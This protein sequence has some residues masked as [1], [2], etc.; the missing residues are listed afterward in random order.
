[1]KLSISNIGWSAENDDQVYKLMGEIG[2][3]GLEIAPTR[4]FPENPYD[5]LNIA[6]D[7]ARKIQ[8]E[9]GFEISS[10]QSIWYGRSE[11]IFGSESERAT[12]V[13]YTRKA[14]D[15]AEGVGCKN[16]VFG[17]P[18]NRSMPTGKKLEDSIPFFKEI[19]EYAAEHNCV[20]AMEANPPIYNTNFIN[21]T[22]QAL[23]L[24]K[25]V[26]SEG[27]LLNLDVGTMV[28][29][30]EDISVLTGNEK[31]IHHAHVSEP[32]LNQ[33][34]KRSLHN[35]L[36]RLL[37]KMN[38]DG[39]VSIEVGKQDNVDVLASMMEYVREVFG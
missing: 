33:I 22:E 39:F 10:M 8:Q 3:M 7:W 23:E 19:G 2:F 36:A 28:E 17:C 12:L 6:G 35:E 20:I 18:R 26:D 5:D 25:M 1:M 29:N 13:S 30:R 14:V 32:G 34:E 38:Y 15:F 24:I 31:Y 21:T 9:H 16:L 27:F 11:K 37:G 4:I